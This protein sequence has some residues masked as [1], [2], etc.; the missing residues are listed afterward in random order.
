MAPALSANWSAPRS[1]KTAWPTSQIRI[2]TFGFN[3]TQSPTFLVDGVFGH[4]RFKNEALGPDYGKNWGSEVWKIPGTNGGKTFANDIR[5]SGMPYISNGFTQWGNSASSNPNFYADRSYT[6]TTNFTKL[7]GSA[8]IPL[9]R[10]HRPP[11]PE[12]LAARSR[13]PA[14]LPE[15]RRQRCR[16]SRVRSP[17]PFTRTRPACSGSSAAP[18]SR[19]STST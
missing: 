18:T 2:P 8:R 16:A 17:A 14:R 10:R 6:F 3:L 13:Q 7:T 4:T 11:R 12:P 5:Y 19:C 15:S 1:G 9:G